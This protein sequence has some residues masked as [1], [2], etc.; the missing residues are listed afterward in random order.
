MEY[1]LLALWFYFMLHVTVKI[2]TAQTLLNQEIK[3]G[4]PYILSDENRK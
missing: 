4:N 1:Y 2:Y 3:K